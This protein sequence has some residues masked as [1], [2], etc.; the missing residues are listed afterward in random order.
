MAFRKLIIAAGAVLALSACTTLR[1][2]S[3]YD[4]SVDFSHFHTFTFKDV[5]ADK[6][7]L[8]DRRVKR[9][10]EAELLSKG[11]R[12]DDEHPDLWVVYHLRVGRGPAL[13]TYDA[14]W[15]YG[16]GWRAGYVRPIPVGTLLVDLVD[17]HAKEL[18]WRGTATD[19]VDID[20]TPA[21][22]EEDLRNAVGKMFQDFPPRA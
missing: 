2:T 14:G 22:K 15:G 19:I 4:R 17:R 7:E 21:E 12:R 18:V 20:A 6:T 1:T 9:A 13:Y 3:D 16:W 10:L 5:Q 8:G 11:I